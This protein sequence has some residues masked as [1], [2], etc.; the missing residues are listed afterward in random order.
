MDPQQLLRSLDAALKVNAVRRTQAVIAADHEG[1]HH[2]A[3]D[4]WIFT[5][6]M[7]SPKTCIVCKLLNL[8][9]W[10]GDWVPDKFPYHRHVKVNRIRASVHQHCRC[11]LCWAG[12]AEGIYDSPF[13]LLTP[14]EVGELWMPEQKELEQLT[15]SQLEY[16]FRF[17][18]NPWRA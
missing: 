4:W 8:T 11:L 18:R 1:F 6:R 5:A 7:T 10:R 15:P 3:Y 12:R 2:S 13:G 17:I 14:E 9:D 16:L